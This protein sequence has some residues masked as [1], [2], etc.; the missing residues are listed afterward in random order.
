MIDLEGI[1]FDLPRATRGYQRFV[2]G[3]LGEP[4]VVPVSAQSNDHTVFLLGLNARQFYTQPTV[5]VRAQLLVGEY[6]DLDLVPLSYDVY[7]I[8]AEALGQRLI[9]TDAGMPDV[10]TDRPLIAKKGDLDR[11]VPPVPGCSGR[12]PYVLEMFRL[13]REYSGLPARPSFCAPFSLA[14]AVR[15]YHNLIQD[16]RRDP[17]FAHRLFAFLVDEVLIPWVGKIREVIP[18]AIFLVGADA[19][20]APPL[21]DLQI[22]EEY[23]VPYALRLQEKV[24]GAF[25]M[26]GWGASAFSEPERFLE[27]LLRMNVPYIYAMDPDPE[28]I[29]PERYKSFAAAHDRPLSLGI[30]ADL[31]RDGPIERIVERIRRYVRAGALGGRFSFFLN[32]IPAD[33]PPAHVQAAIA[34]VRQFGRY[35]LREIDR[36]E[37]QMPEVESLEAFLRRK[38]AAVRDASYV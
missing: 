29:G 30:D 37:F 15:G 8:E 10:D 17:P 20:S 27:T 32:A 19:W 16:I 3:F 26:Q 31:L 4:D 5:A 14:V 34:A 13:L 11:L 1:A 22:Q 21:I 24:P 6:Y 7:N 25:V 12:M 23:I 38:G 28:R 18:E 36:M 35:P 9:Y 2:A 33:T